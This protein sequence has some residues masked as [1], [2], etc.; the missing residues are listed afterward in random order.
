M[1]YVVTGVTGLRNRG[2]E[3]LVVPIVENIQ[4]IDGSAE[5][6]VVTNTPPFDKQRLSKYGVEV[7]RFANRSRS[8]SLQNLVR[9]ALSRSKGPFAKLTD[10]IR[11]ADRLVVTGGDVLSSEYS[12]LQRHLAPVE[13]AIA[14][15]VPVVLLAHSLGPFKKKSEVDT[16]R[17]V[18]N[19]LSLVTLREQL[20]YEYSLNTLG[21]PKT[22]T[23]LT[24]DVAFLLEPEEKDRV[25]AIR[26]YYGL[27][28][29]KPTLA[30]GI[31]GGISKYMKS[32]S[33]NHT[34]SWKQFIG[35]VRKE[36]DLQI[37]VIPHVQEISANN[38]DRIAATKLAS[39]LG[40]DPGVKIASLSHTAS[41]FKGLVGSCDM[42]I[43][44]RMHAC[45]AGL[46]TATPTVAIKYS[47]KAEGIMKDFFDDEI[48]RLGVL[49]DFQD[50]LKTEKG[51]EV[52]ETAWKNRSEIAE[53]LED[54]LP[55]V[56]ELARKNF[57][58][59]GEL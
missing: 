1:K 31:S 56:K 45:I 37:L 14:N 19:Q 52:F 49:I 28:P 47:V 57:E 18:G 21:T 22:K 46:S 41:E 40:Y 34:K 26:N 9:L 16:F 25:T 4:S 6:T 12:G 8:E 23:H 33:A 51:F 38:D 10:L 42:V 15:K 43:S 30:L 44:E 32:D 20:S 2:V 17:K 24:A 29:D 3:A 39:S 36:H 48:D 13:V 53:R 5:I 54:K 55:V 59:M 11:Q 50:F 7:A 27:D 58:L 35:K